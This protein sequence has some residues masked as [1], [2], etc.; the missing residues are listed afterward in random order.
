[1]SNVLSSCLWNS[2]VDF[3]IDIVLCVQ[4]SCVNIKVFIN[5][6]LVDSTVVNSFFD[7]VAKSC[8]VFDR[9]SSQILENLLHA[10]WTDSLEHNC[11]LCFKFL[12]GFK[13]L[14]YSDVLTELILFYDHFLE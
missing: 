5:L 7:C 10:S 11:K 3:P 12:H 14:S 6:F 9:F 4:T 2:D 1:M 8:L 13:K